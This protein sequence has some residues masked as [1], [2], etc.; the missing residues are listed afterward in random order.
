[1]KVD[2]EWT[3]NKEDTVASSII[4]QVADQKLEQQLTQISFQEDDLDKQ[5]QTHPQPSKGSENLKKARKGGVGKLQIE[6]D[7]QG[8]RSRNG[9]NSRCT[10]PSKDIHHLT[11]NPSHPYQINI[12][13]FKTTSTDHHGNRTY[14]KGSR[15]IGNGRMVLNLPLDKMPCSDE[16]DKMYENLS[17]QRGLVSTE[18]V[19]GK[20]QQI[21][22]PRSVFDSFINNQNRILT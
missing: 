7:Q 2:E 15:L 18:E 22:S 8:C 19:A 13:P 1:V 12:K 14:K 16:I 5:Q 17:E 9:N 3:D 20:L 10:Y 11:M 21:R 4:H 6:R